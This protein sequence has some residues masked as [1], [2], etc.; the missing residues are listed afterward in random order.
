MKNESQLVEPG[1]KPI[2]PDGGK[3]NSGLIVLW[4]F[5]GII[6]VGAVI[7]LLIMW[8]KNKHKNSEKLIA[9]LP[10]SAIM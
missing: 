3:R 4:V 9:D 8:R 5:L 1:G 7:I 6:L 2:E 10:D